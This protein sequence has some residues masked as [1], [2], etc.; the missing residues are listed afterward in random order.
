MK[1]IE[2]LQNALLVLFLIGRLKQVLIYS[3]M[4]TH[5]NFLNETIPIISVIVN[6]LFAEVSVYYG[7]VNRLRVEVSENNLKSIWVR[8]K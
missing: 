2:S 7:F 3:I 4:C 6:C 8:K 5:W 1:I